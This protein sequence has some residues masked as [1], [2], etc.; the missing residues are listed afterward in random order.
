[1]NLSFKEAG[2]N[3]KKYSD[4]ALRSIVRDR[5][6]IVASAPYGIV[7]EILLEI[8]G[9]TFSEINRNARV[10]NSGDVQIRVGRLEDLLL[11]K[12]TAGR[13]KDKLFLKRF[14][15]E[16]KQETD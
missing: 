8:S 1:M 3:L 2:E 16:F 13:K 5:K 11:S 9:L 7:I 6:V 12:R 14:K 4:K 15:T 10:F